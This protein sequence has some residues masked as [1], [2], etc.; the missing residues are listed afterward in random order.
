MIQSWRMVKALQMESMP[1]VHGAPRGFAV[2]RSPVRAPIEAIYHAVR[3]KRIGGLLK[4]KFR[5]RLI[6]LTLK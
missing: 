3:L 6:P 2:R 4:C 5:Y 1:D